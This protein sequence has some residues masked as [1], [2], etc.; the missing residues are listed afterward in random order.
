[1]FKKVKGLLC[2]LA[3]VTMAI[4][5]AAIFAACGPVDDTSGGGNSG[6]STD[7]K[8]APVVS[9]NA[10]TYDVNEGGDYTF[11]VD[12]KGETELTLWM[13]GSRLGSSEYAE[14]D[15]EVTVY[16][17]V[18]IYLDPDTTSEFRV[19]TPGGETSFSVSIITTSQITMNTEDV[20]FDFENPTDIV[21]DANFERETIDV[22]R[23][24]VSDY[25]DKQYYSYE[26]DAEGNG[27]F[28]LKK[29]FLS[30]ITDN[31]DILV[32]LTSGD[33]FGFNVKTNL[34]LY[35][36]FSD[37]GNLNPA[38]G[39]G[40][41]KPVFWGATVTQSA[42]EEKWGLV[43][44]DYDHL[45]V[46]GNHYW[47]TMGTVTFREGGSYE[48]TFDVRSPETSAYRIMTIALRK[49][50]TSD[51]RTAEIMKDENG[52]EMKYVLDFTNCFSAAG[53]TGFASSVYDE[54]TKTAQVTVHFTV[55]ADQNVILNADGGYVMDK[56]EDN[57]IV[58]EF[59]NMKILDIAGKSFVHTPGWIEPTT[60][61]YND[62][63]MLQFQTPNQAQQDAGIRSQWH[64]SNT[65]EMTEDGWLK[66]SSNKLSDGNNNPHIF[67]FGDHPWG[68]YGG[69][70]FEKGNSYR[71]SFDL[72]LG[73][74][75][76]Q[77][78]FRLGVTPVRYNTSGGE[79]DPYWSANEL[80]KLRFDLKEDGITIDAEGTS[81]G[82]EN[83]VTATYGAE[84][85]VAHI[86]MEFSIPA[87]T[88]NEWLVY[89][90]YSGA[91]NVPNGF[92][93][94]FDNLRLELV[95]AE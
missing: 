45:F 79:E 2:S 40:D 80:V 7:G 70:A 37:A 61:Y 5:A 55:P 51:P 1:M 19:E 64:G 16:E 90:G 44:P 39:A 65:Y 32:R 58:W 22:V 57:K 86:E 42:D 53:N 43:N 82:Y 50:D 72:K 76:S 66:V 28:T 60:L 33:E 93:W 95:T 25:V 88:E 69:V 11:D 31:A 49:S 73:S 6:V 48:L 89:A 3:S 52:Y 67:V 71:I 17:I 8:N 38:K 47:G 46:F 26:E 85:K 91:W 20:I 92:E 29:E 36:D 41:A 23:V 27:K 18:M 78:S 14:A 77:T 9:G 21:K 4:S 54:K 87:D 62:F 68:M 12:L 10:A 34:L 59:D 83:F 13:D 81:A 15:G 24:G 75:T 63:S 94:L 74:I 35:H 56:D 84:T 30:T